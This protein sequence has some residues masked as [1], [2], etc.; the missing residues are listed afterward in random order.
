M[1]RGYRRHRL[2]LYRH[3]H[4]FTNKIQGD[5]ADRPGDRDKNGVYRIFPYIRKRDDEDKA[6]HPN[7]DAFVAWQYTPSSP[8]PWIQWL[9]ENILRGPAASLS[10]SE[11]SSTITQ[12]SSKHVEMAGWF[13]DSSGYVSIDL[14]RS[15]GITMAA[16]ASQE[17]RMVGDCS[18]TLVVED[19]DLIDNG[20]PYQYYDLLVRPKGQTVIYVFQATG[21]EGTSPNPDLRELRAIRES[22]QVVRAK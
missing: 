18:T 4:E 19:S 11:G 6:K 14:R 20:H 10:E 9:R 13:V 1:R 7:H 15:Q 22:I 2:L 5:R 17:Y 12:S 21:T 16:V 3:L 8:S